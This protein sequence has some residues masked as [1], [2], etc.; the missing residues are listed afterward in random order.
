MRLYDELMKLEG[1]ESTTLDETLGKEGGYL[2][3]V[4]KDGQ[5]FNGLK[6]FDASHYDDHCG[7]ITWRTIYAGKMYEILFEERNGDKVITA[8]E[9]T[10]N[11]PLTEVRPDELK[12]KTKSGFNC[13]H[14]FEFDVDDENSNIHPIHV[15]DE[16]FEIL[17]QGI[18]LKQS[19]QTA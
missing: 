19:S 2:F 1:A 18:H 16:L 15:S 13:I 5:I 10:V 4:H 3:K 7:L 6:I 17:L 8:R 9:K 14:F 11:H 12:L